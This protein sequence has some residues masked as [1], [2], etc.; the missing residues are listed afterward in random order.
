MHRLAFAEVG[1]KNRC[2]PERK[3]LQHMT[4]FLLVALVALLAG[5]LPSHAGAVEQRAIAFDDIAPAGLVLEQCWD[6]G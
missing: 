3:W 1:C 6:A 5:C 2:H 4:C